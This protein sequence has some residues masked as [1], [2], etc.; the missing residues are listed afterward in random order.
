MW[1]MAYSLSK[2]GVLKCVPDFQS[3]KGL[4]EIISGT[5]LISPVFYHLVLLEICPTTLVATEGVLRALE[6]I[7][8]AN[9]CMFWI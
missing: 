6:S 2:G 3:D 9:D 7:I 8:S 4:S 5:I 1:G